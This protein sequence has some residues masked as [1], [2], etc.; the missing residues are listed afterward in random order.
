MTRRSS[1]SIAWTQWSIQCVNEECRKVVSVTGINNLINPEHEYIDDCG[2][3]RCLSCNARAYIEKWIDGARDFPTEKM[4]DSSFRCILTGVVRLGD[5]SESACNF[6]FLV[7]QSPE[8]PPRD[9]WIRS[10][11]TDQEGRVEL[12]KGS[13]LKPTD[14]VGLAKQ[15]E[16][17]S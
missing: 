16:D 15:L 14:I 2:S 8:E 7:S 5:C 4:A 6:A 3:L 10:Y 9:V 1:R 11:F 17:R 12:S 13:I